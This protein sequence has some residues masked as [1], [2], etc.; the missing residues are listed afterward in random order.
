M[1]KHRGI[2]SVLPGIAWAEVAIAG[3]AVAVLAAIAVPSYRNAEINT[4]LAQVADDH[5]AL[6]VAMEAYRSDWG[7]LPRSFRATGET[8]EYVLS[9]LTTPTAYLSSIPVDP[10]NTMDQP[11]DRTHGYWGP[12]YLLGGTTVWTPSGP[13]SHPPF[14]TNALRNLWFSTHWPEVSDGT[15]LLPDEFYVLMSIGPM[16]YW[17]VVQGPDGEFAFGML[18]L[19]PYD[20]TNGA[21]SYGNIVRINIV[22]EQSAVSDWWSF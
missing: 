11:P 22:D 21:E 15:R 19:M 4:K 9:V 16:E 7:V 14:R 1:Q 10:F 12:D 2:P 13:V 17:T 3:T 18:P 8:R 5:Q 20:P 6:T